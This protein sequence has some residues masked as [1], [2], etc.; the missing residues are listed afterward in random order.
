MS[1]KI[2]FWTPDKKIKKRG[3]GQNMSENIDFVIIW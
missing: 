3:E 1:E 2:Q